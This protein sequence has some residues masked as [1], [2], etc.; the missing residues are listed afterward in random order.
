MAEDMTT[1]QKYQEDEGLD[2]YEDTGNTPYLYSPLSQA[3]TA[4][5]VVI[6]GV[7]GKKIRVLGIVATALTAGQLLTLQTQTGPVALTGGL[8]FLANGTLNVF[9]KMGLFETLV[10][11]GLYATLGGA[12]NVGGF[13]VYVTH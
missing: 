7:A 11:D 1:G 4:S 13:I 9:S 8:Q 12:T 10:G 5:T 2:I 6:A 3:V